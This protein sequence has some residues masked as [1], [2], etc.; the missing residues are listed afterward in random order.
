MPTDKWK[1]SNEKIDHLNML[2]NTMF[3]VAKKTYLPMLKL[4]LHHDVVN[5]SVNFLK[6]SIS[7]K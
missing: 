4:D 2:Q 3:H 5:W 1:N 6:A 7:L